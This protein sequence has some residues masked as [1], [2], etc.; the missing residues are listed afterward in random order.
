VET[1]KVM[2]IIISIMLVVVYCGI[3]KFLINSD[4]IFHTLRIRYVVKDRLNSLLP[5]S[6]FPHSIPFKVEAAKAE[7][8]KAENTKQ[9]VQKEGEQFAKDIL[10]KY[11]KKHEKNLVQ[12]KSI[13]MVAASKKKVFLSTM[14]FKKTLNKKAVFLDDQVEE[15][16]LL[17]R[18]H[19]G[20]VNE[21]IQ[22]MLVAIKSNLSKSGLKNMQKAVQNALVATSQR[23]NP[24]AVP[25]GAAFATEALKFLLQQIDQIIIAKQKE[26][27]DEVKL[28][29]LC[30]LPLLLRKKKGRMTSS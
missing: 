16:P 25:E 28:N 21:K 4:L 24:D 7:V 9:Q 1:K 10:D 19:L 14:D 3:Q 22:K 26:R 17:S 11:V 18:T 29:D 30:K 27:A 8:S 20:D 12:K 5:H 6:L 23:Q 15:N 13:K 2:K